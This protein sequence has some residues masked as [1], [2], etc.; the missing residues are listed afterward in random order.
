MQGNPDPSPSTH[1]RRAG[2]SAVLAGTL[3]FSGVAGALVFS[4]QHP[5][6]AVTNSALFAVFVATFP[7]GAAFLIRALLGLQALHQASGER[8]SRSGRIGTRIS[9]AGAVLLVAF[10]TVILTTGLITGA[11][12]EASFVLFGLGFLLTMVGQI[13]LSV[14]LRRAGVL[15]SWWLAPLV[16]AGGALVAVVVFTDP[17]HDL[18]LF[19][20]NAAWVLLG[21]HLI[22][23]A[24]H[25]AAPIHVQQTAV[26]S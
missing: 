9:V 5:D 3:M 19:T 2:V 24:R 16:A 20:F 13:T 14:G 12:A 22:N 11:P 7:I 10:G 26:P 18:G 17:W 21:I 25:S 23:R 15:R 1:A 4:V 8:L 6:G